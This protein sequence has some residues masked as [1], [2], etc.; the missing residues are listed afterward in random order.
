MSGYIKLYRGITEN[1][2]WNKEPY[3]AGQAWIDLLLAANFKDAVIYI[4]KA[5]IR[6]E[7]GQLAWSQLT[8][9]KR[10]KWSRNRV[11]RFLKD[12]EEEGMIE[13]QS[14]HLTTITTI[15]NYS[16]YQAYDT[17][18]EAT[19]DT[20]DGATG[21]TTGDTTG[22]AQ[23]KKVNKGKKEKNN[24][25]VEFEQFWSAYPRKEKKSEALKSFQKISPDQELLAR[26][27][28]DV[29]ARSRTHEW[30]KDNGQWVPHPTTYLNQRRWEDEAPKLRGIDGG[31]KREG[32][33]RDDKGQIKGW[34][35]FEGTEFV[36]N[37]EYRRP[38]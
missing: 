15:C 30:V 8:M 27:I 37:P 24:Y 23:Y 31:K 6:L 21:D 38:A 1:S 9:A 13:Q 3:S 16:K 11:A 4:R 10:W 7:R 35:M 17:T 14:G 20:A 26:I 36:E 19:N 29:Q 33:V 5:K 34:W 2:L 18:G 12:L 25:S 22:G 32:A 28:A